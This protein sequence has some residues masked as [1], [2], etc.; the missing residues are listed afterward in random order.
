MIVFLVGC[1]IINRPGRSVDSTIITRDSV[2]TVILPDVGQGRDSVTYRK[3][4]VNITHVS[5]VQLK[6]LVWYIIGGI[7]AF[8]AYL[9]IK[10]Q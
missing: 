2:H 10:N 1:S 8:A 5:H 4:I 6:P 3:R 7:V 9:F